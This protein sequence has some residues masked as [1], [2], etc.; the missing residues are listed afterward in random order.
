M[1]DDLKTMTY[2]QIA[3]FFCTSEAVSMESTKKLLI[4]SESNSYCTSLDGAAMVS[5][6]LPIS[7]SIYDFN[8][9]KFKLCPQVK[10]RSKPRVHSTHLGK[11]NVQSFSSECFHC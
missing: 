1:R 8:H 3:E 7:M 10:R 2:I 4:K 6:Y 11:G 5:L 9:L